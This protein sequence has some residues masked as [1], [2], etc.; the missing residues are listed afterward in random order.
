MKDKDRFISPVNNKEAGAM[1]YD[2]VTLPLPPEYLWFLYL[3][4]KLLWLN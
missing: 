4:K 3:Q 2:L 1:K